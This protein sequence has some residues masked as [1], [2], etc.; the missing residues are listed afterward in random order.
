MSCNDTALI[1][2]ITT[3]ITERRDVYEKAEPIQKEKI[4]MDNLWEVLVEK[5]PKPMAIM[6]KRTHWIVNQ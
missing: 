6:I 3:A 1:Q 2:I 4:A 5:H